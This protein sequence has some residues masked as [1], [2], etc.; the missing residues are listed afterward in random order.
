MGLEKLKYLN[1]SFTKISEDGYSAISNHLGALG[2]EI[3]AP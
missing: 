3:I 1:I 2:C